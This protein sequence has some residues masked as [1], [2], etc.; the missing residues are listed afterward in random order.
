[1]K[2]EPLFFVKIEGSELTIELPYSEKF[3]RGFNLAQ[4]EN[5]IFAADLIWRRARFFFNFALI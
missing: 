4:G 1:M 3:W 2:E 5:D